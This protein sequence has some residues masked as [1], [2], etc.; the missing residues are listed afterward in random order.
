MVSSLQTIFSFQRQSNLRLNPHKLLLCLLCCLFFICIPSGDHE[1][2]SHHTPAY[3]LNVFIPLVDV[4]V[5]NGPT[6]FVPATHILGNFDSNTQP[7]QICAT[8]GQ[9]IIFDY[10]IRHRGICNKS[11]ESRPVIYLTYAVHSYKVS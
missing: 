6:E 1:V 9:P 7:L 3:A 11:A 5:V 2:S 8:A 10:R 4:T